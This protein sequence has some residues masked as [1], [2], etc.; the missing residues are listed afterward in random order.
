MS[1]ESPS[2]NPSSLEY[3]Q[4]IPEDHYVRKV[5]EYFQIRNEFKIYDGLLQNKKPLLIK[6]QRGL[7]RLSALQTGCRRGQRCPLSSMTAARGQRKAT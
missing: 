1:K 4:V 5:P 7:E 3:I 6:G 2:I